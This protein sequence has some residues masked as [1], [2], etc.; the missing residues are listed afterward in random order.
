M[1]K[2][3]EVL[4][5]MDAICS[6]SIQESWDNS[7]LQ[8]GD[9]NETVKGVIVCLDVTIDVVD[10]AIASGCNLIIAHHP[11]IFGPLKQIRK[12]GD[13]VERLAYKCIQNS[14]A[15]YAAHTNWD[16]VEK[17]VSWVMAKRIGLLNEE[18]LQ[19]EKDGLFNLKVMGTP[20]DISAIRKAWFNAELGKVGEYSNCSFT[21]DGW[22]TFEPSEL[23]NPTLGEK[24]KTEFV[25]ENAIEI[26]CDK[27]DV[28]RALA[29][30]TETS[31]YETIAHSIVPLKNTNSTLGF[32]C[33]GELQEALCLD[34]FL[35]LCKEKY[36]CK[37]VRYN[38]SR[39]I[40]NIK[41]VAVCG[42]SA[43]DFL[44]AAITR[45]ADAYITADIK[46][47]QFMLAD[48]ALTLVDVG[49]YE[50]EIW[51]MEYLTHLI[52]EKFHNFA[53]RLTTINTNSVRYF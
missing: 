30:A 9:D 33:I 38:P 44:P 49:H 17:G 20:S 47:H 16:K 26:L 46:Y 34:D 18:I 12:N 31:S 50:S 2:I 48:D 7:G 53:V 24:N 41:K 42:G 3:K 8:W 29:I 37:T 28:G 27:K 14:I 21:M 51:A 5:A 11:L 25:R 52:S 1:T 10:E 13:E 23:A 4:Q 35:A 19:P 45:K 32:G 40:K 36:A 39:K 6:E 22:G 15:V 43:I